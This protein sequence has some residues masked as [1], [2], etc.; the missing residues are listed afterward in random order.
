VSEERHHRLAARALGTGHST[1]VRE[2]RAQACRLQARP[3]ETHAHRGTT[4]S[5]KPDPPLEEV[6]PCMDYDT[7]FGLSESTGPECVHLGIETRTNR[8]SAFGFNWRRVSLMR[9]AKTVPRA[10]GR[11]DRP[12][13]GVMR[14]YYKNPE[15][16]AKTR[17]TAGSSQATWCAWTRTA[18]SGCRS[19][20]GRDHNGGENVF[21]VEVEDFLHTNPKIKD[22]ACIGLPTNAWE[23]SSWPLSK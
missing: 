22:A 15:A 2:R 23:R 18:S 21:P 7:N 12:G 10:S 4:R 11:V 1:Q 6:L 19:Q 17:A 8:P 5:S 9:T 20:E 16:T 13:D 14:E 3:V